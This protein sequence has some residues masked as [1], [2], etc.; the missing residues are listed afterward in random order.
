MERKALIFNVQKYNMYD[1]PGIRTIV[2]FKGCP[3]RCKWCAN[4]EGLERKVQVM[5]KK[6]SCVDCGLCVQACP[7]GIHTI[8]K[9]TGKHEVRRDIDCTGCRKC[10]Q[11]CPQAALEIT[12]QVKTVSELLE[13]VQED[14]AFYSMSGG[15]VT[16]GGGECTAQT[17]A[18]R[19]LLMECKAEGI[20][21]AI[22]TCGHIKTDKLLQIA[23]YVDLFLFDIKHMDP[24]RHNELTGIGN[25]QILQN[26][27][28]LLK[29]RYNVKVR[30][31]MLKGIND[32]KEEIDQ[33]IQFLL[34]F[35]DD[36]NFKGVDL[37]PYHKMGVGKYAQLDKTYPIEG[38]PS[39][40]K[41]D[42][43]R[44]EGWMKEWNFPVTV[45]RH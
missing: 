21:T 2:F 42:L 17:E 15:G 41:E 3:L 31:P 35:R 33:V 27:K 10:I 26:L 43:D 18:A 20:N 25:E 13:I 7:V 32:S 44:I 38:D 29:R 45:V 16:L 30:M 39:L 28:E 23:E 8:S 37:L 19:D 36:P 12:G 6:K 14:A 5:F 11:V 40:S 24:K 1:G 22:E 4:P 9:E 34:P